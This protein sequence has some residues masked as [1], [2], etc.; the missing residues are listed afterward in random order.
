MIPFTE[1][2]DIVDRET[3]RLPAERVRL[4]EAVGRVLA[5]DITADTDMP[6]FDRS[7][8]DGFAVRAAD[9]ERAPVS[10][11]IVGES[12]AGRS[13]SGQVENGE[14]VRIMTGARVPAGADA[15]QQLELTSENSGPDKVDVLE[16]VKP[17]RSIVLKGAEVVAGTCV[18]AA[19]ERISANMVAAIAA[20]G[21]S[22][23]EV[24]T[25]PSV[26]ILSTGSEI[27]RIDEMPGP[28]QIR[29]SNA[30]MIAAFVTACGGAARQLPLVHD[31]AEQL[32]IAIGAAAA[33]SDILVI[34]G[35]VSVGKY[36][37]TKDVLRSLGAE[38]F[39]ERVKLK[40]GKPTVFGRLGDTL[41]FG[42]PG[43]PVSAAVTF[44]LFVRRAIAKM[45]GARDISLAAGFAAAAHK[46]KGTAERDSFLPAGLGT[47]ESA[48]TV[49]TP[50]KWLGSSDFVGF[51]RA[52][53]L[54]Y[55]PAGQSH[56]A[57]DIVRTFRI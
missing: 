46:V 41:V 14:A 32:S 45:Q 13:W 30:P 12:A 23:V 56:E 3:P 16:P 18:F 21:Y 15:V 53:A 11:Q 55:V 57:G 37:L 39:F 47:D 24:G 54:I 4:D 34:T 50:L 52:D 42:L 27:V 38:I 36:D 22:S 44:Q 29:N 20:F 35:G 40:P 10:L 31:D 28:D 26:S 25:R 8:M 48:R 6:P 33:R 5:A 51:A 49:A 19:G 17:G 1:A 43:N 9:T 2:F 7:Q